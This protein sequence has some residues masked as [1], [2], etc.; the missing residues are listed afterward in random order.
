ADCFHAKVRLFCEDEEY[1]GPVVW[2]IWD[3]NLFLFG[4]DKRKMENN[5]VIK[6][7]EPIVIR[8]PRSECEYFYNPYVKFRSYCKNKSGTVE[9]W[10][11]YFKSMFAAPKRKNVFTACRLIPQNRSKVRDI[12]LADV[13]EC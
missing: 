12:Q 3:E 2:N 10:V 11:T 7:G 1:S 9:G 8:D 5:Y 13:N 4:G 6:K